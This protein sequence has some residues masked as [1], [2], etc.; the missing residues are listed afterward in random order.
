MFGTQSGGVAGGDAGHFGEV[1]HRSEFDVAGAGELA[2]GFELA[3]NAFASGDAGLR[4]AIENFFDG[5][6]S[7][8]VDA[9]SESEVESVGGSNVVEGQHLKGFENGKRNA[10]RR[11]DGGRIEGRGDGASPLQRERGRDFL[12]GGK[13]EFFDPL[14]DFSVARAALGFERGA[15][16]EVG[17]LAAGDHEQAERNAVGGLRRRSHRAQ[18][19]ELAE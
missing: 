16:F 2:H 13:A 19:R 18:A 9:F 14:A 8:V 5:V 10:A 7:G 11:L 1:V 12:F 17:K 15:D 4:A 6:K 3:G